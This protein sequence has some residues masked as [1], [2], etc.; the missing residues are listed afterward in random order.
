MKPL[1]IDLFCGLVLRQ[2]KLLYREYSAIKQLVARRTQNPNHVRLRVFHLA[3]HAISTVFRLM[4]QLD[5]SILSAGLTGFW[6]VWEF[7]S[8]AG[9]HARI[10]E[11][12]SCVINCLGTRILPVKRAPL[13]LRRLSSAILG[14][15]ASVTI[16]RRNLEVRATYTAIPSIASNI[17]LFAASFPSGTCLA[18]QGAVLLVWPFCVELSAAP[19]TE[20]II[21]HDLRL[22]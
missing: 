5:N 2:P 21:R 19:T 18:S 12:S 17:C 3:P 20:Q 1:C 9:N 11:R 4:R 16:W 7:A 8:Q 6:Q 13:H 14:A 22:A 15:V 10:F